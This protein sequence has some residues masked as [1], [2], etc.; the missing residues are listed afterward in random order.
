MVFKVV[1]EEKHGKR[2]KKHK[3]TIVHAK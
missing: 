2:A 1:P 3:R